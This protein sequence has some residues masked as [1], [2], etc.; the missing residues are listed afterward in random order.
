MSPGRSRLFRDL[1]PQTRSAG[2][3]APVQASWSAAVH[4]IRAVGPL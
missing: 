1:V 4:A 3:G 2:R